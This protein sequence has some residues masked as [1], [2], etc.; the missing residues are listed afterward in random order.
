M[1]A[2]FLQP[3][4]FKTV[5]FPVA[6]GYANHMVVLPSSKSLPFRANRLEPAQ[7][8]DPQNPLWERMLGM[9]MKEN[10]RKIRRAEQRPLYDDARSSHGF[11]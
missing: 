2:G 11:S 6:D 7:D 1:V 5:R 3:K 4:G 10:R 9:H 8:I